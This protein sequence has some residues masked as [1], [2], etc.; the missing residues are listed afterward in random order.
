[1]KAKFMNYFLYAMVTGEKVDANNIGKCA[2]ECG[3]TW[4]QKCCAGVTLFNPRTKLQDFSY[5]CIN[6]AVSTADYAV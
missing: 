3:T 1:M 2:A 5:H 4:K 6:Q